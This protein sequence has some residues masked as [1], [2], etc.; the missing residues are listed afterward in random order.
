MNSYIN[1]TQLHSI[2]KLFNQARIPFPSGYEKLNFIAKYRASPPETDNGE[3]ILFFFDHLI[4]QVCRTLLAVRKIRN[5]TKEEYELYLRVN[6]NDFELT[7]H[8][9]CLFHLHDCKIFPK[10]VYKF[11][12]PK[13]LVNDLIGSTKSPES[14]NGS[15][16][17]ISFALL[18]LM[19]SFL[20]VLL[21]VKSSGRF[22]RK[23]TETQSEPS[24]LVGKSDDL[25]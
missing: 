20:T 12:G 4:F 16:L 13:E 23:S 11:T 17:V 19:F 21:L 25:K 15:I 10:I 1:G 9:N 6:R 2:G 22:G 24:N 3:Y 18:F 14:E 5:N 7:Q 8:T